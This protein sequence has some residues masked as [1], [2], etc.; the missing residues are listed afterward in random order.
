MHAKRNEK[1]RQVRL[2]RPPPGIIHGGM[3]GGA[4]CARR[5]NAPSLSAA[6]GTPGGASAAGLT[7]DTE[8][9]RAGTRV[10][11]RVGTI[12]R[13]STSPSGTRPALKRWTSSPGGR[14]G[15]TG[16]CPISGW[17]RRDQ[18]Q[19][20]APTV[21]EHTPAEQDKQLRSIVRADGKVVGRI[22]AVVKHEGRGPVSR[23]LQE[24]TQ[25]PA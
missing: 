21:I 7:D 5:V 3:L 11:A 15:K 13:L 6:D 24:S 2:S 14:A 22:V 18:K 16:Q 1:S 12:G 4:C 19:E 23:A 17:K 25:S 9:V 10:D 20:V 8:A